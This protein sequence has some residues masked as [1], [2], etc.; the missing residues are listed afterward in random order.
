MVDRRDGYTVGK[1]IPLTKVFNCSVFNTEEMEFI[2]TARNAALYLKL[3]GGG[4]F[5]PI[6]VDVEGTNFQSTVLQSYKGNAGVL[7]GSEDEVL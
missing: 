2:L 4:D 1:I 5:K 3:M 6:E 7:V